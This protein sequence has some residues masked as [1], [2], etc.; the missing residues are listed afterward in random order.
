VRDSTVFDVPVPAVRI[1]AYLAHPRHLAVANHEGPIVD[2]SEGPVAT[3]SWFVL[4]FDQLRVRV[5]YRAFDPPRRVVVEVATTGRF[6]RGMRSVQEFVFADLPGGAGTR[7]SVTA[8]GTGGWLPGP[9]ARLSGQLYWRRLRSR[10]AR[11]DA[12]NDPP[13]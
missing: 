12:T 4:A 5:V 6:S 10:I 1:A 7:V 8:E 13:A 2:R 3:G 11:L 9:L